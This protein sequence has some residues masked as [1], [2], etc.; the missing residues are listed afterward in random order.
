MF[1]ANNFVVADIMSQSGVFNAK[2]IIPFCKVNKVNSSRLLTTTY[3]VITTHTI[4]S[5]PL[6]KHT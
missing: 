4:A 1:H 6:T 5:L 2:S 3:I